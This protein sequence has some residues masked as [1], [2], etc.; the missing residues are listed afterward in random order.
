MRTEDNAQLKKSLRERD[1]VIQQREIGIS[2]LRGQVTAVVS[3]VIE[4]L[5]DGDDDSDSDTL[6]FVPDLDSEAD[7][8]ILLDDIVVDL[9]ENSE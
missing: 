7:E 9:V 8:D 2:C 6:T 5:E 4:D 3:K 1:E